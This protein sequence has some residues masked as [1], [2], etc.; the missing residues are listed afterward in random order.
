LIPS[1]Q[2]W[3]PTTIFPCPVSSPFS[4]FPIPRFPVCGS[5]YQYTVY[6]CRI[7]CPI[8]GSQSPFLIA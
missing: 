7:K 5:Y 2:F 4:Q 3:T 6:S 1:L 8:I